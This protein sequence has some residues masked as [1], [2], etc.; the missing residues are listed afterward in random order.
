VVIRRALALAFPLLIGC[1]SAATPPADSPAAAS[2]GGPAADAE[3]PMS[4]VR[5]RLQG[6]WEIARYQSD[7]PIPKEAMPIMGELFDSLRLRFDGS[8][9]VMKAG[10][11]TEETSAFDVSDEHGDDFTMVA[12]GGMFDGASCKFLG[13]D[14]WEVHDR[15]TAWPGVSVLRRAR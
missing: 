3:R 9:V 2:S 4:G 8:R 5:K 14:E 1:G 11:T 6:T 10:K 7:H 15:G 13:D 12:K